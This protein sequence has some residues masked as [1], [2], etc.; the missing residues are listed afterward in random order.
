MNQRMEEDEA[1]D[2]MRAFLKLV[3][4]AEPML[5]TL[6]RSQGLTLMQVRCLRRIQA[7][8]TPVG[9]LA[10]ELS[11]SPTSMTRLLERLDQRKL[12]ER[13]IDPSDRRRITVTITEKGRSTIAGLDFWMKSPV[14]A[15]ISRMSTDEQKALRVTLE[16]FSQKVRAAAE[17]ICVDRE[18]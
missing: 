7:E 13:T 18:T 17:S 8:P 9:D 11:L 6:W 15:A 10:R 3:T 5:S 12:V 1:L 16:Q 2:T 14:M 4:Q